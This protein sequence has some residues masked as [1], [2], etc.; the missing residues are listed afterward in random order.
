MLYA[1]PA[2]GAAPSCFAHPS[3]ASTLGHA[4]HLTLKQ[5][6]CCWIRTMSASSRPQN[7]MQLAG[8]D[9]RV[10]KGGGRWAG[11]GTCPS[12]SPEGDLRARAARR[13]GSVDMGG[14]AQNSGV[15]GREDPPGE[16]RVPGTP[17]WGRGPGVA[18]LEW[19][20]G[21]EASPLLSTSP[22][23]SG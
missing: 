11:S 14:N 20:C 15:L 7:E 16:V 3:P 13:P 19:A 8:A 4:L 9:C 21:A 23:I 2:P 10:Q 5:L 17:L 12:H 1:P 22:S 18:G 6:A